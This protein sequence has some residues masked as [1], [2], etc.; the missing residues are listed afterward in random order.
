MPGNRDYQNGLLSPSVILMPS[1]I[2]ALKY[3]SQSKAAG[4]NTPGF[5]HL[6]LHMS[7]T[8]AIRAEPLIYSKALTLYFS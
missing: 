4:V 7:L 2:K 5:L 1:T 3:V 6:S 8:P